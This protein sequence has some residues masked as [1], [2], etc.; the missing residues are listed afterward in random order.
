V[1]GVL[2]GSLLL[3][4]AASA[5]PAAPVDTTGKVIRVVDGDTVIARIDG[6]THRIRITGL[7]R[8]S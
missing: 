5:A 8:W 2:A 1:A 7:T 4:S 3:V 6:K